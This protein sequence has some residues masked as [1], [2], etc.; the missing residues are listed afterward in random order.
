MRDSVRGKEEGGMTAGA[1]G[2]VEKNLGLGGGR[3]K[4]VVDDG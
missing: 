1:E 2:S 4:E 3:G